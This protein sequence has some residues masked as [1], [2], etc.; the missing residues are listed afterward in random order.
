MRIVIIF[1]A[2]FIATLIFVLFSCA[3][4]GGRQTIDPD[5]VAAYFPREKMIKVFEGG[6]EN[7]G[8]IHVIDRIG[9]NRI[10]VK[11]IDYGTGAALLY[12]V[13]NNEARWIYAQ[14]VHLFEDNYLRQRPNR[15]I[16]MLKGPLRM[17][18]SWEDETGASYAITGVNVSVDTPAGEFRTIEV[19]FRRGEFEMKRYYARGM[20]EVKT[21]TDYFGTR[22]IEYSYDIDILDKIESYYELLVIYF[23]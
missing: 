13:G 11:Q 2:L 6:F 21:Q 10:Q 1:K 18:T 8:M 14:E 20:G 9:R 16:L 3:S 19:T 5:S 22:L 7:E 4:I 17:G 15:D 12:Q 23:R